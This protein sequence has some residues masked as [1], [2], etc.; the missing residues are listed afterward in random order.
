VQ[1]VIER[2]DGAK[3]AVTVDPERIYTHK[4]QQILV[5]PSMTG[6]R[7]WPAG[8]YSPR[9]NA[10]YVPMQNLCMNTRTQDDGRDPELVYGLDREP[11]LAPGKDKM[12]AVWAI[13]AE[14]GKTLW[15]HEQPAGVMAMVAT[16]GGLVFGGDAAGDFKAYDETTGEVLWQTNLGSPISGYPVTYAVDGKQYVAVSTSMSGIARNTESFAPEVM[17]E[18]SDSALFVFALP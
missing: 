8:A 7:N 4:D 2:I 17:P 9:T 16:G 3:G 12:G 11:V 14:T 18:N 5:C 10:M 15:Q 6:G 13:S 1:N